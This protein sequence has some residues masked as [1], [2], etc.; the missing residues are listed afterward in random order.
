MAHPQEE[1]AAQQEVA[2]VQLL[3]L[4]RDQ[5]PEAKVA[6]AGVP[7]AAAT[8]AV[9]RQEAENK[10]SALFKNKNDSFRAVIFVWGVYGTTCD[11][12]S[13]SSVEPTF[14]SSTGHRHYLYTDSITPD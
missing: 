6:V 9:N 12:Q 10:I 14:S 3:H 11:R 5:V 1:E 4:R 7:A 2:D 13:S 8:A